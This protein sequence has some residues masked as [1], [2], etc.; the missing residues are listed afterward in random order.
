MRTNILDAIEH[1]FNPSWGGRGRGR[2]AFEFKANIEF[3]EVSQGYI[4]R[5]CL[6]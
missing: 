2:W 1:T 5:P 4:P 3:Q 6:K